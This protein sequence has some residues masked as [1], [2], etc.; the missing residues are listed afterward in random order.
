ME[1]KDLTDT[2]ILT[3]AQAAGVPITESDANE[4][5]HQIN[6]IIQ[7]I[8]PIEIGKNPIVEPLPID[9][10]E[11]IGPDIPVERESA[12]SLSAESTD[13]PKFSLTE[14]ANNMQ[15][16]H[17]SATEILKIFLNRIDSL[18]PKLAAFTDVYY[19]DSLAEAKRLDDEAHR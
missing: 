18:N 15:S 17:A 1:F 14:L 9:L 7:T 5:K 3:L 11:Y 6:A 16:K 13:Y 8:E 12:S 4:I 2:Q 19:E 10:V